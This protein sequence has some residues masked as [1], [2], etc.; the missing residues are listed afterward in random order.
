M[1][2]TYRANSVDPSNPVM[3]YLPKLIVYAERQG[4]PENTQEY[5]IEVFVNGI[6]IDFTDIVRS[7][8]E[9]IAAELRDLHEEVAKYKQL[10]A[11]IITAINHAEEQV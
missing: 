11:Q 10:H 1:S 6:E 8:N 4:L 9:H 5:K 3:A 7:M 2:T